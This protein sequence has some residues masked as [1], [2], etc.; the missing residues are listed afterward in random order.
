MRHNKCTLGLQRDESLRALLIRA[1]ADA[2][3]EGAVWIRGDELCTHVEHACNT[4]ASSRTHARTDKRP[5]DPTDDVGHEHR[6]SKRKFV[7]VL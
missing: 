1:P 5:S 6:R 7:V 2:W 4:A 3:K